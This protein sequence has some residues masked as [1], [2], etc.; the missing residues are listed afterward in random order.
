MYS[1]KNP[2]KE[3]PCAT[4]RTYPLPKNED[5]LR[6]FLIV[7]NQ[8]IMGFNGPIEL[9]HLAVDAAIKREGISSYG[10]F[11]KVLTLGRWWVDRIK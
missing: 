4:C 2:P 8:F 10:C 11:E 5:A 9:N 3:P 6:I 7:K 1:R